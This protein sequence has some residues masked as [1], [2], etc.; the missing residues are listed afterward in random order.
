MKLLNQKIVLIV[1]FSTSIYFSFAQCGAPTYQFGNNTPLNHSIFNLPCS[2]SCVTIK[3][4]SPHLKT[5]SDYV[6]I[7]IGYNPF[8][9]I[10]PT[11]VEDP[12]LY[13]DDLFSNAITLPFSFCFYDSSYSK[14]AVGSNGLL[15]FDETNGTGSCANAY[16]IS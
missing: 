14:I 13:V 7:P 1:L 2:Q 16:T 9:Y 5:A 11:G 6:V 12:V 8:P 4:Q 15:T 3:F 10:T